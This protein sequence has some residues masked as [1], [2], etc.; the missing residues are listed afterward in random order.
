MA[1]L[2]RFLTQ[3]FV[4]VLARRQ[5][6]VYPQM[7]C[8]TQDTVGTGILVSG[9]FEKAVLDCLAR[10]VFPAL[11]KESIAVDIGANVGNHSVYFSGH[12]DQVHA[13]EPNQR[14]FHL[15]QANAMISPKIIPY[16]LG[17]S[18]SAFEQEVVYETRNVGGARLAPIAQEAGAAEGS[19]PSGTLRAKF[20]LDRLDHVLPK[21]LHHR[22]GFIKIDVEGHE[23][24]AV[25]G[26]GEVIAASSPVI[27]FEVGASEVRNG[28]TAAKEALI[29]L[30]YDHF[31][32]LQDTAPFYATSATLAKVLN[33]F[34][35]LFTSTKLLGQLTIR[36][37]LNGFDGKTGHNMVL[38]SRGPLT[39]AQ[40]D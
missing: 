20:A 1:E 37:M 14:T 9:F 17:C 10:D 5:A 12:F 31:Y 35:V 25:R 30:G 6:G 8:F 19:P 36:P 28:T 38:A 29:E 7:A 24:P 23:A 34:S 11:P 15:L 16:H 4:R 18:D 27:G 21:E 40:A 39:L 3:V 33:A 22:V 13:F 2:Q 32:H 26:A